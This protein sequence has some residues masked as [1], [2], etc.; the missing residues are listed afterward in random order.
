[1]EARKLLLI[2]NLYTE[3]SNKPIEILFSLPL[4]SIEI[5]NSHIGICIYVHICS[6]LLD[7]KVKIKKYTYFKNT[8]KE[9]YYVKQREQTVLNKFYFQI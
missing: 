3:K 4:F 9:H 1:M 7:I 2:F 8:L 6:E 5:L